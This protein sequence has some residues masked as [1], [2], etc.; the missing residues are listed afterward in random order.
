M[1]IGGGDVPLERVCSGLIHESIH[2]LLYMIEWDAPFSIHTTR[3]HDVTARSP[4]TG[5][6]LPVASFIHA[7]FV[8]HGLRSFWR[9][10]IEAKATPVAIAE[11]DRAERGFRR[12][13]YARE[14]EAL[15]TA[16]RG[17]V[18]ETLLSFSNP[19][20]QASVSRERISVGSHC[21]RA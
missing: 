8:W 15:G 21:P 10:A 12:D 5:R 19:L 2:N 1:G 18:V 3:Q 14:V 17:D 4:W 7:C 11:H 13:E 20:E 16:V 9:L 6:V